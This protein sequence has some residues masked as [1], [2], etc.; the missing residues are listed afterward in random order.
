LL[1]DAGVEF[2]YREYTKDPLTEAEIRDVL[3]KLSLSVQDVLRK[4]DAKKHG[5]TG[6]EDDDTLIA[7]MAA[8]PR[9]LQRPILVTDK[10]AAV[11]R[12]V[13][14]LETVL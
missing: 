4:R 12:P 14:N 3:A 11:G 5:F 1:D 13:E 8:H 7:A 6:D 9:M 10:G 2:E